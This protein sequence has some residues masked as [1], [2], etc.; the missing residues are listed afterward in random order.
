MLLVKHTPPCPRRLRILV[1][2]TR[3][4]ARETVGQKAVR[5]GGRSALGGPKI[6]SEP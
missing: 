4:N 3:A 6:A 5:I 2:F 1:G